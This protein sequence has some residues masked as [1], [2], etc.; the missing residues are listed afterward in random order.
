[1]NNAV[2]REEVRMGSSRVYLI[3]SFN[4]KILA[5]YYDVSFS[6]TMHSITSNLLRKRKQLIR[7][8]NDDRCGNDVQTLW[9]Q[10]MFIFDNMVDILLFPQHIV[11]LWNNFFFLTFPLIEST[12]TNHWFN[13]ISTQSTEASTKLS[14]FYVA[15][16][17]SRPN[18]ISAEGKIIIFQLVYFGLNV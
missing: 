5:R 1:M 6:I 12:E 15:L 9:T 7:V 14:S 13:R 18:E 10:W 4:S 3:R 8:T 17:L 16:T 2:K 11:E